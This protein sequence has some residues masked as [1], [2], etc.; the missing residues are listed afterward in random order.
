MSGRCITGFRFRLYLVINKLAEEV[1]LS[2]TKT[3]NPSESLDKDVGSTE[4]A[5]RTAVSQQKIDEVATE[6]VTHLGK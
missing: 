5:R 4:L 3:T 6:R 1:L 2:A